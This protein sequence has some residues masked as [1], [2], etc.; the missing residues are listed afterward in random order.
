MNNDTMYNRFSSVL[1]YFSNKL[2]KLIIYF[3][4][5]DFILWNLIERVQLMMMSQLNKT[6][7]NW[8]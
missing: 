6:P 8:Q 1:L 7:Q 5:Y 2:K 3:Y 4:I